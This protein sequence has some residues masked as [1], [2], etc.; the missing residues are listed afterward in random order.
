MCWEK[1]IRLVPV[2]HM[3][4]AWL[5]QTSNQLRLIGDLI[6]FD[7]YLN[8]IDIILADVFVFETYCYQTTI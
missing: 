5:L 4:Y 7:F 6:V 2:P 3:G 1:F 8:Y